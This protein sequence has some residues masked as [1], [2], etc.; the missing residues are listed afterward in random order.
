MS[1]GTKRTVLAAVAIALAPIVI[2]ATPQPGNKVA[3]VIPLSCLPIPVLVGARPS[4]WSTAASGAFVVILGVIW[5]ATRRAGS[6]PWWRG[7]L[8][9]AGLSLA[10]SALV[11]ASF[12]LLGSGL[13]ALIWAGTASA[14]W[15][16]LLLLQARGITPGLGQA[17]LCLWLMGGV[18]FGLFGAVFG[19]MTG[20][21]C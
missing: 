18:S 14:A 11:I 16:L 1:R 20:L 7:P 13:I 3:Y 9:L 2:I 19:V 12:A 8:P 21:C 6:P 4:P 15:N 5:I 17:L 10:G